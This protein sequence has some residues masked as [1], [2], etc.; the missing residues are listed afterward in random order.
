M[1]ILAT[2]A[3]I[4][5]LVIVKCAIF[6][7]TTG[8]YALLLSDVWSF[9]NM[10]LDSKGDQLN[11]VMLVVLIIAPM[12]LDKTLVCPGQGTHEKGINTLLA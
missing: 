12:H 9:Q 5:L 3:L 4:E 2:A 10:H 1:D 7:P 8:L 11:P 6:M